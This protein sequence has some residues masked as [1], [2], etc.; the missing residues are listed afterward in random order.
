M[1]RQ[2]GAAAEPPSRAAIKGGLCFTA[3]V[4]IHLFLTGCNATLPTVPTEVRIPVPVA[5]VAQA[6]IPMATFATDAE[7]AKLDDGPFVLALARDRL[8]RAGH[9]AALEA[10]LSGCVGEKTVP[11][12]VPVEAP[13]AKPWWKI[14]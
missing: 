5:C 13:V 12:S 7:I 4:I 9:I 14:F 10:I 6:D 1:M 8:E 3:V 11:A 2:G